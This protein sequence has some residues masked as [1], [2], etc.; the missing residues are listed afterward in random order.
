MEIKPIQGSRV[1]RVNQRAR[2]LTAALQRK[3][4][5]ENW[6]PKV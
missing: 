1:E 6:F 4:L 2:E 3:N 5:L